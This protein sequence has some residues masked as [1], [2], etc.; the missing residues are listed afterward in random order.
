MLNHHHRTRPR[1]VDG[2]SFPS[3]QPLSASFTATAVLPCLLRSGTSNAHRPPAHVPHGFGPVARS[4]VAHPVSQVA[5]WP[6]CATGHSAC[7][8]G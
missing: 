4:P 2:T 8:L 6:H 1:A 3:E 7:R 5:H